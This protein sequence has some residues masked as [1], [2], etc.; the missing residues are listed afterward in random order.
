MTE[1]DS[2]IQ[3]ETNNQITEARLAKILGVYSEYFSRIHRKI[4]TVSLE[5]HLDETL[6]NAIYLNYCNGIKFVLSEFGYGEEVDRV[7]HEIDGKMEKGR[8]G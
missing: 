8:K 7:Q 2:N 1:K 6:D 4:N 5:K 3:V